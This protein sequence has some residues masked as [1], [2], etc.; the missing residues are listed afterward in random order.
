M[1]LRQ[2][3]RSYSSYSEDPLLFTY[4]ELIGLSIKKTVMKNMSYTRIFSDLL[5]L[6]EIDWIIISS[7][8]KTRNKITAD[9]VS[10]SWSNGCN[11]IC[12]R[13]CC[14]GMLLTSNKLYSIIKFS[15][16]QIICVKY[17]LLLKFCFENKI[18]YSCYIGLG[19]CCYQ[20]YCQQRLIKQHN[21]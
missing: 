10:R 7:K 16:N 12:H 15:T 1:R 11:R 2:V 17:N 19:H 20:N 13:L 21:I 14:P 5:L 4:Y 18:L 3:W 8:L 6:V 9:Y